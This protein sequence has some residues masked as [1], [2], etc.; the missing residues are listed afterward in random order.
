MTMVTLEQ[1]EL[2]FR[3]PEIHEGVRLSVSLQRTLRVP[4]DG[5]E[6]PLPAGL[7]RFPLRHVED[8]AEVLPR[9]IQKRGGVI[10][11]M[12][13]AE[14][15]WINFSCE[16]P[17]A[18]Q[19]GTGKICAITG[20]PWKDTLTRRPE[21]NY[22]VTP[23]QPWLDGYVVKRGQ[24]RQF[25]AMPLG[26]GYTVEEQLTGSAQWGGIQFQAFPLRREI[27]EKE[28]AVLRSSLSETVYS[29]VCSDMGI[30][31]GGRITQEIYED[32]R[33]LSHWDQLAGSRV[34]IHLLNSQDWTRIT[35]EPPPETPI[36][37]DAYRQAGIPWFDHYRE[38]LTP[39][40]GGSGL[41]GIK[42]VE[43]MDGPGGSPGLG[44]VIHTG[45]SKRPREVSQGSF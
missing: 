36:T 4:D 41:K 44:K 45:P 20:K 1:D 6:Y 22:M 34:F 3:A 8:F 11:P 43:E 27:W 40:P 18:V 2:V 31:P 32:E 13:Q 10:V 39:R 7:G 42:S 25:V 12:Y 26:K 28:R 16:W 29:V 19:V 9:E 5:R 24:V 17:A 21:Q 30:A 33:P 37:A 15:L 38:D 14:A 23:E 35:G